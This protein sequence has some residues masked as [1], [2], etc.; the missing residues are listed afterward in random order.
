MLAPQETAL[1]TVVR[2]AGRRWTVAPCLAE[3]Q[4]AVGLDHDE[5]RS[6]T[7]WYRPSTLV[8]WAYA[9]L[10]VLRTAHLPTEEAPKKTLPHL[11]PSSLAACKAARGLR[12]PEVSARAVA[13]A[14]VSSWP[15]SRA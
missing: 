6:W 5:V 2:V 1:A 3:A 8:L 10:T 7:G 13:S 9:L 11:T 15:P 4:G 12:Y 14:G